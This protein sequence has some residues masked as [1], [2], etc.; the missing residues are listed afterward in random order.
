MSS[1]QSEKGE[2]VNLTLGFGIS[3]PNQD[4]DLQADGFYI[5]GEYIYNMKSWF[6]VRP[7]VAYINTSLDNENSDENLVA[8]GFDISSNALMVG[9]KFRLLAPVPYVALFLS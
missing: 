7:Y 2:F 5:K 3:A 6:S 8:A 1:A 4:Y 9:G